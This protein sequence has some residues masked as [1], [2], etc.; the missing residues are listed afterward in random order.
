MADYYGLLPTDTRSAW[1][2]LGPGAQAQAGGYDRY[3]GFWR[4]IDDLSVG[5]VSADGDVVTVQMVYTT[6]RGEEQE[7][8]RLRVERTGDDWRIS[9]D[10]GPVSS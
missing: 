4:T 5:A 9:Q 6:G 8:R 10:L 7:T 1:E 3:L 2:M